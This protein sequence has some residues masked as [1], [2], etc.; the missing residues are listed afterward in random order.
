MNKN[1]FLRLKH[2]CREP[3]SPRKKIEVQI[4]WTYFLIWGYEISL[5]TISEYSYWKTNIS[6]NSFT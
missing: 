1:R 3:R 6:E 4:Q 2:N 5:E